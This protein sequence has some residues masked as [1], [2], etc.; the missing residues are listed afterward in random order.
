MLRILDLYQ[1]TMCKI[2]SRIRT[3]RLGHVIAKAISPNQVAFISGQ[4]IQSHILLAFELVIGY[5]RNG[6]HPKCMVQL[7]MQKAYDM[8]SW[9]AL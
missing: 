9:R 1:F 3:A 5:S 6:G 2:I 8:V 4:K 7:D